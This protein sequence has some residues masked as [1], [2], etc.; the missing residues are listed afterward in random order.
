MSRLNRVTIYS[1]AAGD[2][3]DAAKILDLLFLRRI[4]FTPVAPGSVVDPLERCEVDVVSAIRRFRLHD[5]PKIA[6]ETDKPLTDQ[7]WV[8]SAAGSSP[9]TYEEII[10]AMRTPEQRKRTGFH[11]TPP[12]VAEFVVGR[13]VEHVDARIG[14]T[15]ANV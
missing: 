5:Q 2:K 3:L 6:L 10:E 9:P 4:G 15:T 11:Q 1:T 12:N 14:F 8:R 7:L 13:V